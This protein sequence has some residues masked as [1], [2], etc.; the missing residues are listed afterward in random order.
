LYQAARRKD[1][2]EIVAFMNGAGEFPPNTGA[3]RFLSQ[4][5]C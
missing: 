5:A 3:R 1:A 4:F 2:E